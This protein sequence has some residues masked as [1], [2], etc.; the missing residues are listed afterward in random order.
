MEPLIITAVVIGVTVLVIGGIVFS[1]HREKQRTEA[2]RDAARDL[3]F[4]FLGDSDD[5]LSAVFSSFEL[6]NRGHGRKFRNVMRRDA[7][8]KTVYLC[9]FQYT[10]GSGKN[11][12]THHQ[13]VAIIQSSDMRLPSFS[14]YPENMMHR[15][16]QMLGM[17]D[18]DFDDA[19]VFSRQFVLRGAD[20]AAIRDYF[21]PE[22]LERLP[23]LG[24]ISVAGEGDRLVVWFGNTRVKPENIRTFFETTFKT[25]VLLEE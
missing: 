23:A 12:S 5:G 17:Q 2:L 14:M 24:A 8:G 10:T 15:L 19:P 25:H 22:T 3:G 13:T 9:D 21:A 1:I 11:S 7:D 4:E 18:I 16:G 6:A 20:E